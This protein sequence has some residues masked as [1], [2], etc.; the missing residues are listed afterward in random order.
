VDAMVVLQGA[1]N[2]GK[3]GIVYERGEGFLIMY[4]NEFKI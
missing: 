3:I 4:L 1:F 2:V